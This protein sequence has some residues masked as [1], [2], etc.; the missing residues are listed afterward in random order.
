MLLTWC[1]GE[2]QLER[3]I[4][5]GAVRLDGDAGRETVIDTPELY[6]SLFSTMDALVASGQLGPLHRAFF[7]V[8]TS[9]GMRRGERTGCAIPP[10]RSRC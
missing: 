5:I 2:G 10:A 4:V 7:I 6:A 8:L 3:N 1:V 9:T